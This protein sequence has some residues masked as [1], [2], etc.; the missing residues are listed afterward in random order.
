[1]FFW[2]HCLDSTAGRICLP[3]TCPVSILV[4]LEPLLRRKTEISE[5]NKE[6]VSILVFLEPL[7]RLAFLFSFHASFVVSILVFLEPL[8]RRKSI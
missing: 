8:L 7:L 4:F 1:M 5:K 2:N 6:V 3:E